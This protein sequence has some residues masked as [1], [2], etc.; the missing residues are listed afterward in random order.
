MAPKRT[1]YFGMV[2][3]LNLG[4]AARSLFGRRQRKWTEYSTKDHVMPPVSSGSRSEQFP[5]AG[6]R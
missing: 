3:M 2:E 5:V 4:T 1:T 6:P